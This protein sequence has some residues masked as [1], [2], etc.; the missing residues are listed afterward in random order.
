[1]VLRKH[2]WQRRVGGGG[3]VKVLKRSRICISLLKSKPSLLT[4]STARGVF[5]AEDDKQLVGAVLE[6]CAA[7]PLTQGAQVSL[8]LEYQVV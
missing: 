4:L 2:V 8:V 6:I 7:L 1:M 5:I 3:W